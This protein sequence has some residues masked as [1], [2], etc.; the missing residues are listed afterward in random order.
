M[1][2]DTLN[3]SP[4]CHIGVL[5]DHGTV[6]A[7][8]LMQYLG[9]NGLLSDREFGFRKSRSTKD[10]MLL[11]Y[12]EI[13]TMVD[14]GRILNMALLEFSKAF[15]MVSYVVLLQKL[16]ELGVC[17]MLL[18]WIEGCLSNRSMRVSVGGM[19]SGLGR[20]SAGIPQGSLL[21]PILF[22]VY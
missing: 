16:R 9:S 21:G 7:A 18:R 19:S 8:D 11:V 14:S 10:Q 3:Y 6:V 22:L 12:S 20:M 13:A 4:E 17:T 5:Q 15:E 1:R 2:Y